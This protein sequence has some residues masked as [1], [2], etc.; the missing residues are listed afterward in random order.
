M[1]NTRLAVPSGGAPRPRSSLSP[2]TASALRDQTRPD[3]PTLLQSREGP[4]DR[5]RSSTKPEGSG[6]RCSVF[7][8]TAWQT[9][10]DA[11]VLIWAASQIVEAADQGLKTSRFFRFTPLPAPDRDRAADRGK[12]NYVRLKRALQRPPIHGSPDH[13]PSRRE[14]G[15]EC[16]SPGSTNGRNWSM[17]AGHCHG[18]GIRPAGVVLSRRSRSFP[19]PDDRP[20]LL[21][22]DRWYRTMAVPR[23]P[24]GTPVVSRKAGHSS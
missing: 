15:G 3:E 23:R 9:I 2:T 14:P 10:W 24:N 5:A 11:D 16:S 18:V 4:A 21:R 13:D 6:S 17:R 20:G 12:A 8:S 7:P 1:S 22:A 19:R